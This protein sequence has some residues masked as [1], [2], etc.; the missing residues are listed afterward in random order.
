MWIV[1]SLLRGHVKYRRSLARIIDDD[2]VDVVIVYYVSDVT[3]GALGLNSLLLLLTRTWWRP[4][5]A[6]SEALTVRDALTFKPALILTLLSHRVFSKLL[7]PSERSLL[8]VSVIIDEIVIL[9]LTLL[10]SA[11]LLGVI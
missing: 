7:R 5:A 9:F 1:A 2:V 4:T 3:T 6:H 11:R 8:I 10:G